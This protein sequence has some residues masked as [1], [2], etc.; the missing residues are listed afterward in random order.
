MKPGP[1]TVTAIVATRDRPEL[2][3]RTLRSFRTQEPGLLGEVI[4]VFDGEEPDSSLETEFS[5]L[6]V[7]VVS[8][9]R[10]PGLAGARNTGIGLAQGEWVAFCDDDDE[11]LP[12]RLSKQ[13]ECAKVEDHFVVG[14]IRIAT[15]ERTVDRTPG[16]ATIAMDRLAKSRVMEAHSSTYLIKRAALLGPLGLIDEEI[17]GG[18]GEDYDILLRSARIRPVAAVDEPIAVVHWNTPSFYRTR[19]EMT[20]D[21]L[22]YIFDKTPEI[23]ASRPGSARM[24]GQQAFALAGLGRRRDALAKARAT[25]LRDPRQLRTYIAL[26]IM[27]TPVRAESLMR[28]AN[29]VGRGI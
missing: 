16:E 21:A 19:W 8:N 2:L 27:A 6:N 13:L 12:G 5:D 11:W 15:G 26:F 20:V 25:F 3:R 24:L 1:Q 23:R 28:L 7:K 9:S 29:K 22:Q 17:P 18:L 10:R 4:V 14:G